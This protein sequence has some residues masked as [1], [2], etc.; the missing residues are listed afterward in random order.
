MSKTEKL[1]SKLQKLENLKKGM[2]L[3]DNLQQKA[4]TMPKGTRYKA[5]LEAKNSPSFEDIFLKS[6][7]ERQ[8]FRESEKQR[9]IEEKKHAEREVYF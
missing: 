3:Q 2:K 9:K 8:A 5:I 4:A 1:E 6:D 7:K